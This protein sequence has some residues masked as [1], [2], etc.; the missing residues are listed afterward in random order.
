[1]AVNYLWL[2][3]FSYVTHARKFRS[4]PI[5]I[6]LCSLLR[7]TSDGQ[8]TR[9]SPRRFFVIAG[10][11]YIYFP[12]W[13][14]IQ[15]EL[16]DRVIPHTDF[17]FTNMRNDIGLFRLKNPLLIN[18]HV[19]YVT[20]PAA[21]DAK[22]FQRYNEPCTVAGWG[23]HIP[24]S[25]SG[26]GTYL[27]H[28]QLPLIQPDKCPVDNVDGQVHLCA[29]VTQ[30]G[31]DACQGDSGGPLLCEG[32][33]VG[34][35]SWGKGCAV[36]NSPGVYTRLDVYLDWLNQSIEENRADRN[37]TN[38]LISAIVFVFIMFFQL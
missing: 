31:K 14:S 24:G 7:P 35:V 20:I 23:R 6:L 34:I 9:L 38:A 25:N 12:S 3:S 13:S 36:P 1:M 28:V 29:G 33:Q 16:I 26:A 21:Y 11:T 15:L 27:R 18:S 17:R 30:G 19:K 2:C 37:V 5:A 32:T 10:A 8:W 22:I 4:L